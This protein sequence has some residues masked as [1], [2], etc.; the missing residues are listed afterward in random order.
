MQLQIIVLGRNKHIFMVLKG[1]KLYQTKPD[2]IL[3][4]WLFRPLISNKDP[5]CVLCQMRYV[6]M[7]AF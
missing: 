5:H 6:N 2:V 4:N 1:H 3:K 7:C